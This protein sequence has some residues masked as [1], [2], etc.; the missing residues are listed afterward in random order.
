MILTS[1]IP[2]PKPHQVTDLD[3]T[4]VWDAQTF[5]GVLNAIKL[6]DDF[7]FFRFWV[8]RLGFLGSGF[9]GLG[10]RFLGWGFNL[11]FGF[12]VLYLSS[13]D[14]LQARNTGSTIIG[15][16]RKCVEQ[17]GASQRWGPFLRP[18]KEGS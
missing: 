3:N 8:L 4:V 9:W 13:E 6:Q 17:C 11:G 12:R 7:L 5:S 1:E 2:S 16:A 15:V 14:L 18:P 10:F